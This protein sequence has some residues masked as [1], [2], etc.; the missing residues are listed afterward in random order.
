M[1]WSEGSTAAAR[2]AAMPRISPFCMDGSRV[3][4]RAV[5]VKICEKL[6]TS[7]GA[8]WRSTLVSGHDVVDVFGCAAPN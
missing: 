2:P 5:S 3:K 7:G 6:G 8:D 4:S 1:R